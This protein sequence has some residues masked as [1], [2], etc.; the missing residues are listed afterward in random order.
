[1]MMLLRSTAFLAFAALITFLGGCKR[2]VSGFDQTPGPVTTFL[3][4]LQPAINQE[5]G[6]RIA[7]DAATLAKAEQVLSKRLSSAGFGA[8]VISPQPPDRLTVRCK[9]LSPAQL[10]VFRKHIAI[11]AV[12]D[13]RTVHPESDSLL[14]AIEAKQ[15]ILDPAW[16]ILSFRKDKDTEPAERRLIVRRVP[17]I[18]GVRI[19][20]A[21]AVYDQQGWSISIEFDKIGGD[22]FFEI[23][24]AMRPSV[25]RFAIVLDGQIISAPTTQVQGGIAGGSCILTGKYS[26][27]EAREFASALNNPLSHPMKIEEESTK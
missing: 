2:F 24:R 23:T 3:L 20:S 16:T 1:M 5:T 15:S 10:E 8:F 22:K 19:K 13:F 26:E 18:S 27:K 25:D 4:H 12:L 7:V 9:A 17:E 11:T 14:P 6:E 21:R